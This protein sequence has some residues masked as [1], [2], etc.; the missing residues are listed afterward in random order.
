[1]FGRLFTTYIFLKNGSN[2]GDE[3]E[4]EAGSIKCLRCPCCTAM[5]ASQ[6]VPFVAIY[7]QISSIFAASTSGEA[8]QED[9]EFIGAGEGKKRSPSHWSLPPAQNQEF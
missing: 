2:G 5:G 9:A 3:E 4:G 7:S 1:M 6:N 8:E